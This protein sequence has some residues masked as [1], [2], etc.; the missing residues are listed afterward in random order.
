MQSLLLY[1]DDKSLQAWQVLIL[2]RGTTQLENIQNFGLLPLE[3]PLPKLRWLVLTLENILS[4][5]L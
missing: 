2:S 4:A 5:F 3:V 1:V